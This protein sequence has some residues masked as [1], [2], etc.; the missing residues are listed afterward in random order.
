M[1]I[2]PILCCCALLTS[3]SLFSQS[4]HLDLNLAHNWNYLDRDIEFSGEQFFGKNGVKVA[5]NYFQNTAE[6]TQTWQDKPRATKFSEHIGFSLSYLRYVP[7]KESNIE[8]Y[9]YLKL[10][11]F[12]MP[13]QSND[14]TYGLRS[15]YP[16]W[17]FYSGIG[18][19]VKSKLYRQLYLTASADAGG[20][21]EHRL[22]TVPGDFF[23][24]LATCGSVGLSYRLK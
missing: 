21:F 13:Y 14:E 6:E 4:S 15:E 10:S 17:K 8:L 11:G 20:R 19:Q 2:T 3:V 12:K 22:G 18:L 5:L 1:K 7:L 24:G 23:N 9:P 16:F